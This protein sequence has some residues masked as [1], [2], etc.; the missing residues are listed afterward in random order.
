MSKTGL[1][2][3]VNRFNYHKRTSKP[4]KNTPIKRKWADFLRYKYLG[5]DAQQYSNIKCEKNEENFYP[6]KEFTAY[7][8]EFLDT[9]P[10]SPSIQN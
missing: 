8:Y 5:G 4:I 3:I 1:F 10:D 2:H 7:E 6:S 9:N